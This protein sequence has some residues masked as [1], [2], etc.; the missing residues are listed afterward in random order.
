MKVTSYH[1]I[2]FY[3]ISTLQQS[4]P[5]TLDNLSLLTKLAVG[6]MHDKKAHDVVSLDLRKLPARATDRYLI[7]NGTSDRQVQAIA[8]A[9]EESI[10]EGANEKPLHREGVTAGEWILLDYSNLVVHIFTTEKRT[11]YA[12]E[13][14][15]GDAEI[16]AFTE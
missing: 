12:L 8:R 1:F 10:A 2:G 7:C 15:W 3:I 14:L 6:A 16:Q 11:F 9:V 13:E 4:K 5:T